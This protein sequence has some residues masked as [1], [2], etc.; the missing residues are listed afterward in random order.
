M[1]FIQSLMLQC[2]SGVENRKGCPFRSIS[3]KNRLPNKLHVNGVENNPE[4]ETKIRRL[5]E[6]PRHVKPPPNPQHLSVPLQKLHEPLGRKLHILFRP[7]SPRRR[8][9]LLH[10]VELSP[11]LLIRQKV[12]VERTVYI[13]RRNPGIGIFA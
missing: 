13:S 1:F 3:R 8:P 9:H 6:E 5:K 4:I 7:H 11:R 2:D 12:R 10:L